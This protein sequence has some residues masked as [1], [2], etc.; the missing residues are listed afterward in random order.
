MDKIIIDNAVIVPLYYDKALRFSQKNILGLE[1][2]SMN[3]LN[4]KRVKKNFKN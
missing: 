3:L 4:L 2:N 1:G